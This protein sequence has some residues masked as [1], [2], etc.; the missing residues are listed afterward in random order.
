MRL[1]PGTLLTKSVGSKGLIREWP[2]IIHFQINRGSIPRFFGHTV[3][4]KGQSVVVVNISLSRGLPVS[5]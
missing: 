5:M 1:Q 4:V 3:V 2:P